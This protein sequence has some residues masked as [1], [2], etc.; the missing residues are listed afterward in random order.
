MLDF[1]PQKI[2]IDWKEDHGFTARHSPK[3]FG[4]RNRRSDKVYV[5]VSG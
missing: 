3:Y 5:S 4:L 2:F 1:D